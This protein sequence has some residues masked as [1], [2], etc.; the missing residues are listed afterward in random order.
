MVYIILTDRH[1]KT[2]QL[3]IDSISS[4]QFMLHSQAHTRTK[5]KSPARE[6]A[7]RLCNY[8]DNTA[9]KEPSFSQLYIGLPPVA[10]S[11]W[12]ISAPL[13]LRTVSSFLHK[14][15]NYVIMSH[16]AAVSIV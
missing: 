6:E 7:A 14:G 5:Q 4:V 3:R 12:Q 16:P 10:H 11:S 13:S 9:V 8:M 15:A 2:R 1:I